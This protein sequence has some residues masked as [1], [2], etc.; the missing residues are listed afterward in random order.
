[1]IQSA[2]FKKWLLLLLAE[3]FGVT[4]APYGYTLDNGKTGLLGTIRP[5]SAEVA[6]AAKKPEQA[7]VASHCAHVLFILKY[8][9]GYEHGNRAQPDWQ[10]VWA[11]RIVDE[12]AWNKLREDLHTAYNAVVQDIE[13][14]EPWD[15]APDAACMIL[16]THCAYHL[17][18]IRQMLSATLDFWGAN[19]AIQDI[20]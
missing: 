20:A 10:S 1:M 14:H 16:S 18:E 8:F 3:V 17:G 15:E 9:D 19:S 4:D 13:Q 7:T 12:A 11:T 6:S 5:V 2:D